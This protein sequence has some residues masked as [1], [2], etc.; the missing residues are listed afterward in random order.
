[1]P[2]PIFTKLIVTYVMSINHKIPK[3]TL[4]FQ[5]IIKL[6]HPLGNLKFTNKGTKNPVFGMPIP[7]V[8]LNN[9]IKAYAEYSEYLAKSRGSA[10]TKTTC[11]GKGLL[12]KDGV[13]FAVEYSKYP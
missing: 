8:M 7:D 9:V 5:H 6:D 13:E 4:S 2:Y 10:P 1:M 3:R 12:T 11:R